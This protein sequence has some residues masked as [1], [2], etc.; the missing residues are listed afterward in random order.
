MKEILSYWLSTVDLLPP[1]VYFAQR[2]HVS[3]DCNQV[4]MSLRDF[5][6]FDSPE[7][8]L[9]ALVYPFVHEDLSEL[10]NVLQFSITRSIFGSIFVTMAVF[11]KYHS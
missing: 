5:M 1:K 3:S 6:T 11:V 10:V 2:L 4:L 7:D 9:F 8:W